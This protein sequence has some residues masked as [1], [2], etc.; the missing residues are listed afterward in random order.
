MAS[1][2]RSTEERAVCVNIISELLLYLPPESI[3]G[4]VRGDWNKTGKDF[5][6]HLIKFLTID[7]TAAFSQLHAA[8]DSSN[9]AQLAERHA[10]NFD[11]LSKFLLYLLE[12]E[13]IQAIGIEPQYILKLREDMDTTFK[14]AIEFL[15]D[16][17]DVA[18]ATDG[19]I[20]PKIA[21]GAPQDDVLVCSVMRA[22]SIWL[23]EDGSLCLDAVDLIDVFV[24]L[25]SVGDQ[26]TLDFRPWVI[27]VLHSILDQPGAMDRFVALGGQT[28]VCDDV[29]R[30]YHNGPDENTEILKGIDEARLLLL[31][32]DQGAPLSR[33]LRKDVLQTL[34][35]NHKKYQ[36]SSVGLGLSTVLLQVAKQ[37]TSN[38]AEEKI[39]AEVAIDLRKWVNECGNEVG[40]WIRPE[41]DMMME[42]IE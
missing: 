21:C 22:L 1:S 24:G 38:I 34:A 37:C 2:N 11:L 28:T 23:S 36:Q 40:E 5:G 7:L 12:C 10:A 27:G 30:I 33:S 26:S 14:L 29:L 4:P 13:D 15:R 8:F 25:W 41:L 32:I 42:D 20:A 18:S 3:F 39:W 16:R 19:D 9:Y 6:Y 17:W 31:I 35:A